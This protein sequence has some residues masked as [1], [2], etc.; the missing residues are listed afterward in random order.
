MLD[1]NK[2]K[3]VYFVPILSKK[4]WHKS[5][6]YWIGSLLISNEKGMD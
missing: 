2:K 5:D 1:K 6:I 4:P 3:N